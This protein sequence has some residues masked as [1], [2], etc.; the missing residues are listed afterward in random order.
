M[1]S[2]LPTFS[3][4]SGSYLCS[5][6]L[7]RAQNRSRKHVPVKAMHVAASPQEPSEWPLLHRT[8]YAPLPAGRV[9][10]HMITAII[11]RSQ[12]TETVCWASLRSEGRRCAAF[13]TPALTDFPFFYN[14]KLSLGC[15][16]S[17]S[18][19]KTTCGMSQRKQVAMLKCWQEFKPS[20]K[21]RAV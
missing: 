5:S 17:L 1:H 21:F 14:A 10:S 9:G 6:A 12:T 7:Q 19:G 11:S 16:P 15:G 18:G 20:R 13:A 2:W 3:A 8:K 4:M